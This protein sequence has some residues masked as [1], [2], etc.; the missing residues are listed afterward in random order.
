M[1]SVTV[2]AGSTAKGHIN[3]L[4]D[5]L[6]PNHKPRKIT[7]LVALT[8]VVPHI[9]SSRKLKSWPSFSI[10]S[11]IISCVIHSQQLKKKKLYINITGRIMFSYIYFVNYDNHIQ[12]RRM[13]KAIPVQFPLCVIVHDVIFH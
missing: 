5:H 13:R 4:F 9:E 8:D 1:I 10:I 11:L 2:A 6:C 7:A 3:S 12:N